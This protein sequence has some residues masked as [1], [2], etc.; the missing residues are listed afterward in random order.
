MDNASAVIESNYDPPRGFAEYDLAY[1]YH[2]ETMSYDEM[3]AW[4]E[5]LL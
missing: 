1:K 5:G 4:L 3:H 2:Y